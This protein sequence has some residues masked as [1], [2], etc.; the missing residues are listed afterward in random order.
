MPH[1]VI[2]AE[3]RQLLWLTLLVGVIAALTL[4]PV[5]TY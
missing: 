1:A 5:S 3:A 4:T 2:V